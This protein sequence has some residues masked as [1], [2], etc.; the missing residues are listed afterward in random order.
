MRLSVPIESWHSNFI[1][2]ATKVKKQERNSKKLLQ[3]MRY[4]PMR[5][6]NLNT[7][8]LVML[9]LRRDRVLVEADRLGALLGGNNRV[10]T[11]RFVTPIIRVAGVSKEIQMWSLILEDFLI[12][13]RFL[14]NFSVVDHHS[15]PAKGARHMD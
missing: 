2:I 14:N 1:P 4:F 9:R 8:S 6:R 5:K 10:N 7:T 12:L 11:V 3:H 15:V 13:L